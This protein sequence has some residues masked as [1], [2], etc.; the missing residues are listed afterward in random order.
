MAITY[1][2]FKAYDIRGIYPKE[3]NESTVILIIESLLKLPKI[4]KIIV[5]RDARISSPKIY[6]SILKKINQSGLKIIAI[7]EST[8]PMFYYLSNCLKADL[9]IMITASHNPKEYNGLKIVKKNAAPI[10]GK[11]ILHYIADRQT[12]MSNK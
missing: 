9:G 2:I 4:K 8:T 6:R 3:I 5:A 12:N 7:G 1:R 10:S 11:E